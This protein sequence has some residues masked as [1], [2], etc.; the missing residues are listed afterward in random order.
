ML[1]DSSEAAPA[2]VACLGCHA[3]MER[4]GTE[5][6]RVGGTSGIWKL[7]VGEWAEL[8]EEMLPLEI[9]LCR[10]CRRIELRFPAGYKPQKERAEGLRYA[11]PG[12]GGDVYHGQ[13]VCP[14]CGARLPQLPETEG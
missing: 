1:P 5:S 6:F 7:F 8:G 2:L 3:T 14:A 4:I 13:A 12:C 10:S 9:W 11:C